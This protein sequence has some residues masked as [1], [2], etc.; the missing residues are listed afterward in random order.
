M[1]VPTYNPFLGL[2]E[3]LTRNGFGHRESAI[4]GKREVFQIAGGT[5]IGQMDDLQA[6][7]WMKERVRAGR[8][9]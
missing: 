3:N 6:E 8:S 9:S 2:T 4:Y 1:A 7:N 5:A